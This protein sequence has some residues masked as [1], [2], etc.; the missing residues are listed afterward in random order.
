MCEKIGTKY[1]SSNQMKLVHYNGKCTTRCDKG[2]TIM[3]N[4]CQKCN[5]TC[6]KECPG[7]TID[8]L[9]KAKEYHGCTVIV[10]DGLTISIKRGGRESLESPPTHRIQASKAQ[11][12][13]H[14]FHS[15][16]G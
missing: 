12:I 13:S 10:K 3:N 6:Q 2:Y 14:S 15:S 16:H 5:G 7:G 4:T 11:F 9:V 8:S 1:E